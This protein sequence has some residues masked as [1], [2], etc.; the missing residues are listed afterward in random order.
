MLRSI[1][2]CSKISD[3]LNYI[4]DGLV[5]E[6]QNTPDL[7]R[8]SSLD[9]SD[10]SVGYASE[11][12]EAI[13]SSTT[14]STPPRSPLLP[15]SDDPTFD[16]QDSLQQSCKRPRLDERISGSGWSESECSRT[17]FGHTSPNVLR[18]SLRRPYRYFA[19]ISGSTIKPSSTGF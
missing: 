17:F 9:N 6:V 15:R 19:A 2:S 18:Q 10:T 3:A 4:S 7:E 1:F 16:V 12:T 11:E 5:E 8:I 14:R 13:T